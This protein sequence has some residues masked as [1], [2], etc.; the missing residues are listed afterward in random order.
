MKNAFTGWVCAVVLF[1]G[2]QVFAHEGAMHGMHGACRADMKTLCGDIKMGDHEGMMKCMKDNDDKLS[3]GCKAEHAKMKS[4]MDAIMA[5]CKSDMD[6]YC[7][8][9]KGDHHALHECMEK[10]ESKL[11]ASCKAEHEKMESEH[12]GHHGKKSKSD[13]TNAS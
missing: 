12:P 4:R 7:K 9:A 11:T 8:D 1:S 13:K 2:F 6:T 10:N 5:A 3:A